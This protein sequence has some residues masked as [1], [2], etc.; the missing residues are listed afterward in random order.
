MQHHVDWV[1]LLVIIQLV[2]QE[3]KNA[4]TFLMNEITFIY[5][6]VILYVIGRL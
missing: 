4:V 5:D 6:V 2:W 1:E 3:I